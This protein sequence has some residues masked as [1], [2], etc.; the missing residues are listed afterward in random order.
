MLFFQNHSNKLFQHR[1]IHLPAVRMLSTGFAIYLCF[2]NMIFVTLKHTLPYTAL[3]SDKPVLFHSIL[4]KPTTNSQKI[5]SFQMY[6]LKIIFQLFQEEFLFR[7]RFFFLKQN[8]KNPLSLIVI[9]YDQHTIKNKQ[10]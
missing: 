6:T 7:L 9:S 3:T 1:S 5:I 4:T 2:P 8:P 10:K